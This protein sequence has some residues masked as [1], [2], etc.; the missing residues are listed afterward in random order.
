MT[1]RIDFGFG[2]AVAVGFVA[3]H[4]DH[5]NPDLRLLTNVI[6]LSG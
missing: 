4:L 1:A 5:A 2:D 6:G 3:H